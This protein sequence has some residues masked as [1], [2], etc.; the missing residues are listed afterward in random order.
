[1]AVQSKQGNSRNAITLFK[2]ALKYAA[3]PEEVWPLIAIEYQMSG[4][5]ELASKYL[6][7][8]LES[9]P[10]DEI[11]IYNMALCFDLLEK[12]REGIVYF[13]KFIN[14]NPY[15]EIGW[16]HRGILY[17]KKKEY[18]QALRAIDYALLID[19]TF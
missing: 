14:Q 17:A 7:L 3:Y 5:Y 11:A 10:E 15:S 9:N 1:A 6:K 18:E 4:N 2:Q 19:E 8:T 12:T 13:N 16:Y